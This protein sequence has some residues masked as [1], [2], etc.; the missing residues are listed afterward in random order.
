MNVF[1][2]GTRRDT[3]PKV[4]RPAPAAGQNRKRDNPAASPSA[5]GAGAS[6]PTTR[7]RRTAR[8]VGRLAIALVATFLVL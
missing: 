7:G 2:R 3:G 1:R 6:S 5:P 8:A 4:F